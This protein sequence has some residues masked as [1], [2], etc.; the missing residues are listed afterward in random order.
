MCSVLLD[1]IVKPILLPVGKH[2]SPVSVF[3][4][5][6]NPARVILAL[7]Y[8]DAFLCDIDDINLGSLSIIL[9]NVNVSQ[10]LPFPTKEPDELQ[11]SLSQFLTMSSDPLIIKDRINDHIHKALR[12]VVT[13]HSN[14]AHQEILLPLPCTEPDP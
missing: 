5:P 6:K 12:H 3:L 8:K 14:A 13:L 4:I 11:F 7:E 10:G 1:R 2:H 9:W